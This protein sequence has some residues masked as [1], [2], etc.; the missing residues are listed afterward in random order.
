MSPSQ[1][2]QDLLKGFVLHEIINMIDFF[3]SCGRRLTLHLQARV[4]K[5]THV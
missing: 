3:V 1:T 2:K 5:L 4:L